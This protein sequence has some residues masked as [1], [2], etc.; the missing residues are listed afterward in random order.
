MSGR[1][2]GVVTVGETG[3]ELHKSVA[4]Q[5]Q[6]EGEVLIYT[7]ELQND[8]QAAVAPLARIDGAEILVDGVARPGVL[9]RDAV[10]LNTVFE[11]G[12]A[13][14]GALWLYHLT[15]APEHSYL[16]VPPEDAAQVD[17]VAFLHEGALDA[18]H[19]RRMR[20]Q[21]RV[22]GHVGQVRITNTATVFVPQAGG[23]RAQRSNEVTVEHAGEGGGLDYVDA[24][25]RPVFRG[26][27]GQDLMFDFASGQCNGTRGRDEIEITVASDR[28]GDVETVTARESDLNSGRFS[29]PPLPVARMSPPVAGDNVLA[30][31][32]GDRLVATVLCQSLLYSA[33]FLVD[34]GNFVFDSVDNNPVEGARVALLDT[35]GR[36]IEAV[37]TDAEGFFSFGARTSGY[38]RYS[39]EAQG[40]AY[41]SARRVFEG[42]ARSL[43]PDEASWGGAFR[44]AAGAVMRGDI[45]VDPDFGIP[46]AVEKR[47]DRARV[48][49]GGHAVYTLGLSNEMT[50]ALLDARLVDTPPP[51]AR[52]VPGSVRLDGAPIADPA[53]RA[54]GP[55]S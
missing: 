35:A 14:P 8:G 33:E 12:G 7:L 40:H 24:G 44:H 15:G 18:G 2:R 31:T 17:A 9:V 11:P 3:I 47:V 1:G 34:P 50:E 52:I 28:T 43:S 13:A 37:T 39:V 23:A 20:F 53:R 6:P 25:M 41:P 30:A 36:E 4:R 49:T 29:A 32:R 54:D 16:S 45:P 27:L 22:P 19:S 26:A 46:I 51:G 10:P 38:Y 48:A 5:P 55:V 42:F 21:V